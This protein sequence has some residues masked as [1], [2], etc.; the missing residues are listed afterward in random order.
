MELGGVDHQG[1]PHAPIVFKGKTPTKIADDEG[2]TYDQT[3]R[4]ALEA[5]TI[6]PVKAKV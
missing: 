3:L 1:A 4:V 5:G 6:K 2:Q